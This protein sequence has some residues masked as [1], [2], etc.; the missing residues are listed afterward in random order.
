MKKDKKNKEL[1][2]LVL[3]IRRHKIIALLV[4]LLLVASNTYAWFTY[5]K[6]VSAGLEANVKRWEIEFDD[7]DGDVFMFTL[8]D[9]Y[10]G[11][12]DTSQTVQLSNKGDL[13][14]NVHIEIEE[15]QIM[16]D[17][18]TIDV[19][20]ETADSLQARLDDY[21]FDLLLELNGTNLTTSDPLSLTFTASWLYECQLEGGGTCT[22]EEAEE[23]DEKDTYWGK[24]A[25]TFRE[26]NPSTTTPMITVIARIIAVQDLE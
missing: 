14:A 22:A 19:D 21:P 9:L 20:G 3:F 10:P 25:Y 6:I 7:T 1:S 12:E 15:I 16:G 8:V 26:E 5:N 13:N 2:P 24:R 17:T 23:K 18:Y 11:M 4:L